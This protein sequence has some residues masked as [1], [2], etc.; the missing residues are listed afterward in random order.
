M[1]RLLGELDEA[2]G[3]ARRECEGTCASQ[4]RRWLGEVGRRNEGVA[5]AMA[6]AAMAALVVLA[7]INAL[8]PKLAARYAKG[9]FWDPASREALR[10]FERYRAKKE[11]ESEERER[12]LDERAAALDARE[13]ELAARQAQLDAEE[14]VVRDQALRTNTAVRL[15]V[16]G[17]T[18]MTSRTTLTAVPNSMLTAMFSGRHVLARDDTGAIFLDHQPAAFNAVLN[19]LRYG[20]TPESPDPLFAVLMDFFGLNQPAGDAKDD[21]ANAT[22]AAEEGESTPPSPATNDAGPSA[23]SPCSSTAS[24]A[25]TTA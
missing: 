24:A 15:N 21:D 16:G 2:L 5:Y 14:H 25:D 23:S 9:V 11:A 3:E 8:F 20:T 7:A 6:Y 1:S 13:R 22:A 12:K 10:N 4:A 18:L 19:F 17:T